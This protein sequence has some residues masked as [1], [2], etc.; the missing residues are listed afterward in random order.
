[1]CTGINYRIVPV[2]N[3]NTYTILQMG[4]NTMSANAGANNGSEKL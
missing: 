2:T 1:V 3:L 4:M